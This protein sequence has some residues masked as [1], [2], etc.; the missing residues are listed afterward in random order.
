MF[1][2]NFSEKQILEQVSRHSHLGQT[3][4]GMSRLRL[5]NV[6]CTQNYEENGCLIYESGKKYVLWIVE[7]SDILLGIKRWF[8]AMPRIFEKEPLEKT[9]YMV[10]IEV[11]AEANESF[12]YVSFLTFDKGRNFQLFIDVNDGTQSLIEPWSLNKA[13]VLDFVMKRKGGS[14][15]DYTIRGRFICNRHERHIV[16]LIR[17]K[18]GKKQSI[19]LF[20]DVLKQD[21]IKWHPLADDASMAPISSGQAMVHIGNNTI[22]A[23]KYG[24][25][26]RLGK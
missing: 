19:D 4:Q 17:R 10:P 3:E 9:Y 8:T 18:F 15:V 22:K 11:F 25:I 7:Y 13:K 6:R 2:A 26:Y 14:L 21:F 23:D 5:K 24:F 12:S 1:Y 20:F 16:W